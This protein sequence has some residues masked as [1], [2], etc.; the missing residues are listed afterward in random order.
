MKTKSRAQIYDE[1]LVIKC[2]QGDKQAFEEL[3]ERWQRRLWNYAF[4]VTGSEAT[5][6]DIVQEAWI[7]IIKGIKKLEDVAVFPRWA[8]RITN[9]K[10]VDALRKEQLQSRL[11][12]QLAEQRQSN[13]DTKQ[14][15]EKLES[16]SE[17]V[18]R[19]SPDCRALL[20][21]RYR[22]GFD[23]GQIA[24]ILGIPEGTVKSRISRTLDE[25]RRL[26]RAEPT[27]A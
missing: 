2:R 25:L 5:A 1:I 23:I 20:A 3:V 19:L 27:V 9:N 12:N 14:K 17:A 21:L 6:W 13:D 18:E 10:C 26:V 16:L 22:E 8:F 15:N 7:G 24:E 11:N 4:A